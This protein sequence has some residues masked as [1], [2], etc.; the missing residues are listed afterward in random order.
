[1]SDTLIINKLCYDR[2]NNRVNSCKL[3][4]L[5]K[6]MN[7]SPELKKLLTAKA[8]Q[9]LYRS[10]GFEDASGEYRAMFRKV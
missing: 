7:K 2:K 3:I 10:L 6:K 5:N 1:M 9:R 4:G 8:G